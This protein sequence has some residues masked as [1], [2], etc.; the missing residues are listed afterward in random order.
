MFE[1][2]LHVLGKLLREMA[3]RY[4]VDLCCRNYCGDQ[5]EA[6]LQAKHDFAVELAERIDE[7]YEKQNARESGR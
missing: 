1:F 4:S 7:H 3:E 2:S 5:E 6:I